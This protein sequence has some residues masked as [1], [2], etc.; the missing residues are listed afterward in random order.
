MVYSLSKSTS[1]R[2]HLR[3]A[4]IVENVMS[5]FLPREAL[6]SLTVVLTVAYLAEEEIQYALFRTNKEMIKFL[7]AKL[8][9]SISDNRHIHMGF[10]T[11]EILEGM[12]RN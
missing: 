12:W 9:A 4:G 1:N 10:K 2:T 8:L 5:Y 3:L 11:T 7:C 6:N